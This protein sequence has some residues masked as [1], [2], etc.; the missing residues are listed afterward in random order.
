MARPVRIAFLGGLGR[1]GRNCTVVEA[2]GRLLLIDCG[3][4]FPDDTEPGIDVILP[5]F[6][7][8][9]ERADRI[10]GCVLTHAHEDHIGALPYALRDLSFPVFGAPFALGL[11]RHKLDEAGLLDRTELIPIGDH[12]RRRI[13]PF[14]CEFLPVTHSTPS[15][16][17]TIL[18]TPQGVIVHSGDFK[19]DAQPIDGRITDIARVAEVARTETV[20]VLLADSTNADSP[21]ATRSESHIGD[22]LR[23]VFAA[24]RGRRIIV[25]SFASH[26]HRMQQVADIAVAEGRKVVMLGTSMVRNLKLARDIGLMTIPSESIAS[27]DELERLD[28]AEVCV[29]CTG[30]Q[31][32]ARAVLWQLVQGEN[33]YMSVTPHDTI[34]LSSHPIPGNE[35]SVARLRNRLALL[36]ATVVHDGLLEVHTSGHAKQDELAELMRAAQPEYF[37][38]IHGES[39]HL[40]EHGRLARRVLGLPSSRVKVC[41]DGD[42]LE[43][44]EDGL[45]DGAEVSGRRVYVHGA[46]DAIDD[47]TLRERRTLG[48][49]GFVAVALGVDIERRRVTTPIVTSRGWTVDR[50]RT[51]LHEAVRDAVKR[52]LDNLFATPPDEGIGPEHVERA[53]RRA[54]GSTV[55]EL[56]RRRPMIVPMV[57]VR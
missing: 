5:D 33:R 40:A 12:Q 53:V 51:R 57:S 43:L 28:P 41:A 7:F 18:R 16:L 17:L 26:V 29:M 52:S 27:P 49:D 48:G 20:R 1:I 13:G 55:A 32:E 3:Q 25:A 46:V 15:S 31:G 2:E 44:T 21:G 10:D 8:L 30:S 22:V 6:G 14:D 23:G 24:N 39:A 47:G 36:G 50:D 56:T 4:M 45:R 42:T 11:V 38:P 9:R 54:A 35:M 19:L 37:V 34:V